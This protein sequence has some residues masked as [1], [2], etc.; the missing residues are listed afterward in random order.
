VFGMP[1]VVYHVEVCKN[2]STVIPASPGR[3]SKGNP[4]VSDEALTYGYE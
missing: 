4:V 2:A 1:D 3:W